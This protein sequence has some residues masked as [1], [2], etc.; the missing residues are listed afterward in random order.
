[1][2]AAIHLHE[3]II[4]QQTVDSATFATKLTLTASELSTAGFSTND[5]ILILAWVMFAVDSSVAQVTWRVTYNSV[6]LATVTPRYDL[7]AGSRERVAMVMYR[8]DL[9]AT[10][11]DIDLDLARAEGTGSAIIEKAEIVAIRLADFGTENTDW[12]WDESVTSQTH[13]ATFVATNQASI[14][15]TP[16][17]IED[18]VVIGCT[19][20]TIDQT[21]K[22]HEYRI[23]MDSGTILG[24]LST[25]EV[26]S[27]EGES[28]TEEKIWSMFDYL[29]SL[30]ASEHTIA[31]EIRDDATGGLSHDTVRSALL[32]FRAAVWADLFVDEAGSVAVTQDTDVQVATITDT[33]STSQDIVM[34]GHG[35]PATIDNAS[36]GYSW[37]RQGGSTVIDPVVN[38][39]TGLSNWRSYDPTDQPMT[40]LLAFLPSQS[41]TLDLDLFFHHDSAAAVNLQKSTFLI[42]GMEL[43]SSGSSGGSGMLLLR[44]G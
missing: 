5:D 40:S 41:G 29:G 25:T 34:L 22:N 12:H 17:A 19:E 13:T 31:N 26:P 10:I 42:W 2:A 30:A 18:W 23:N 39:S 11:T 1:M 27:E 4:T 43:A 14:T 8:V 20:T 37:I 9:G 36:L 35:F 3:R 6:D 24:A 33:L 7:G 44:A 32:I 38:F 28:A 16:A 15:F 21:G